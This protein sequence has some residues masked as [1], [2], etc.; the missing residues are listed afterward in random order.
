MS[1][2]SSQSNIN[3]TFVIEPLSITG[4]SPTLSACTTLFSNNILSCSGDTNI[5]M[6]TGVITFDGNM[7]TNNDLSATTINASTYYSG[8]TNL[9]N[10]IDANNITGG[11]FNN[12]TDTL[13]LYKTNGGII[14]VTGI[15][16]T[17]N[18]SG[19]CIGDI[20]V[21]NIHSCS[22]L[23][24]NPLD[25]GDIYIGSTSA[26][27]FTV[28][29]F[30]TANAL[31]ANTI[32]A[33]TYYNLPIDITIT[34]GSYSNSTGIST[35]T[36]N[37]GGTFTTSG[38]FKTTDDIYSTGVT[39]N[40]GTYDLTIIRNDGTSFSTNLG[41][42]STDIKITGGTYDINTGVVTFTNST[43]GTFNVSG[44]TSG[45]TDTTISTFSYDNA[46]TLTISDSTGGTFTANFNI[47]TGLTING[48]L[49]VT[50]TS[51]INNIVATGITA[52]SI[53][54]NTISATTYLNLPLD[55]RV[56]GGTSN[57][58]T[59]L[60]TFTNNTGGTFSIIGLTDIS[61]TAGT[62]NASAG[63]VTFTNTTGGTFSVSGLFT[64]SDDIYTTG[65]TYVNNVLTISRNHGQPDLSV[66]INTMTGLT[67]NGNISVTGTTNI[68]LLTATTGNFNILNT[69]ILSAVTIS[70]TTYFG[71]PID[72]YVTGGTYSNTTG[73][74]T[75]TNNTGGMFSVNGF[76]T[77][78]TDVFVTGGTFNNSTDIITF[79]N[80][81]GGTFNVSGLTDYFTT[82][83]T[84]NNGT[85]LI[86]YL[87]NDG[88]TGYTV[89]LSTIDSNDTY[90]TGGTF[91]NVTDI[92]TFTNNSGGT[93]TVTGLND[94]FTTGATLIG[95]TV[96]FDRNDSLSAYT[97]DLSSL[98]VNDTYITGGT[99]T[100]NNLTLTRNDNVNI[101]I[102]IDN[103]TGLTAT[104]VSAT[105]YLGLPLDVYVTG[106][107]VTGGTA[108]FTNIT[109]GTFN[110][111]GFSTGTTPED[112]V[113]I[114]DILSTGAYEFTGAS[115]NTTTT[116][117][118][119]QVKG[120]VVNNTGN[121]VLTP[122]IIDVY[123]TGGTNLSL[124]YLSTSDATFLLISSASTL[125]Q[126]T[127][128]P[129][130]Q[131]RRENIYIS[132]IIHP[133]RTTVLS[134]NDTTDYIQSPMSALRDMFSPIKLINDGIVVSPNGANL[135]FNTSAGYLYGMGINYSTQQLNPNQISISATT[136]TSFSYRTQTGG[137]SS[138]VTAI[139]PNFYD[140]GGVITALPGGSNTTTNQRIYLFSIDR[141]IVQYG[142]Q[143]YTSLAEALAGM[144]SEAFVKTSNVV[145]S[146]VL[147][148]ILSVTKNATDLSNSSEAIFTPASMM[149]EVGAGTA[150]ISTTTLQQAYNN[151]T[152]PEIIINSTLDGVTI[153]NGTGNPDNQ[154]N[155]LEGKTSGGTTSFIRA[156]GTISGTTF[157]GDGSQLTGI[158][159]A[160]LWSASTGTNS[161]I[162]NNGTGNLAS[163]IN[164][165]AAGRSNIAS[166]NH[167]AVVGGFGNKAST[168]YSAVIGGQENLASGYNSFVG[169]GVSN[170]ATTTNS[171][172]I[173]GRGSLASGYISVIVGGYSNIVSGNYSATI[174]GYTNIASGNRSVVIGGQNI[175][176]STDDTVYVPNLNIQTIGSG[177]SIINLGLDSTGNVV[178]GFTSSDTYVTGVTISSGVLTLNRNQGLSALTAST[179]VT[180]EIPFNSNDMALGTATRVV[181]S[182]LIMNTTRF[183]GTGA[184]DDAGL[185][186]II[187][188]NY[189]DNPQFY[190]T[191]RASSTGTTS[192]KTYIDIYTGDTS[193]I[194]SLTTVVETLSFL[195]VP[196]Y[197][198]TFLYSPTVNSSLILSGGNN[199]HIR[200]YR[201]PG[202]VQD[203][204]TGTLDMIN[205][206]FKYNSIS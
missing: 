116:I 142:Q 160:N 47:L 175:T 73:T 157:Y 102:N 79:T 158:A 48:N 154:T 176:G 104:T 179:N 121:M 46:N 87:R 3:Q 143:S 62:Y 41:V 51:F 103:F 93:F 120:Y 187:P 21:S 148:G 96:Y 20:W 105:T 134:I 185:S 177:T 151:S 91:N 6:G 126:Q 80:N 31:T 69:N 40:N 10:I 63:T 146:G 25:E 122:E 92:I 150:G 84:Y 68:G 81:T 171:S 52:N 174:G 173:G 35:F 5:F 162:A 106:G 18:T 49:S 169:G 85:K 183:D 38:F 76:F 109:G 36:N 119:G 156:D 113:F 139:T 1:C 67:I 204:Y 138:L 168:T 90:V 136:P 8:G 191:W 155:L 159:S 115:I 131:E 29:G 2:N 98:E 124:T 26:I 125:I 42:L 57:D 132:K 75:F 182:P 178:T 128:F 99:F 14:S 141:I 188:N 97:L 110:V 133:N 167:S 59:H 17:G 202:D 144:K 66:L 163:G 53:I 206:N 161:I 197:S 130:P 12:N 192:A 152:T 190:F 74:A 83:G 37:T 24:I 44:F 180:R 9:F 56:T 55:I 71:L 60:Y 145:T 199:M 34:G 170:S 201:D 64:T 147:I 107:T 61:V 123:Y 129:T 11:T 172:I 108:T 50:G 100:N 78:A 30:I 193:E 22:P 19:D 33:T 200:I 39:I 58:S 186:F 149:G 196:N 82:G 181:L 194:G 205:F 4:G 86:T 72:V 153:Q 165:L 23:H 117:D 114:Y 137:T 95:T 118:V 164:A 88:T 184:V 89:D 101:L 28:D 140:V 65:F 16:F 32:S 54:T 13:S 70:A 15:N 135:N 189:V 43:G 112:K 195:D 203:T 27:T 77:G 7:Y 111:S 166:G 127:T 45:M 94:N 198:N